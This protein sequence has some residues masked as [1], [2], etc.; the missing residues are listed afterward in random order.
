MVFALWH[1]D[2]YFAYRA[3]KAK[4]YFFGFKHTLTIQTKKPV[5]GW[6]FQTVKLN[7]KISSQ[8]LMQYNA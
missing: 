7:P 4:N 3:S 5:S 6:S 1:K 2:R 8:N